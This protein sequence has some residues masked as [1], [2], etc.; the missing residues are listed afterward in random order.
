MCL[1]AS[2]VS[3]HEVF[4]G[5]ERMIFH[6]RKLLKFDNFGA[7]NETVKKWKYIRKVKRPVA[8]WA[9]WKSPDH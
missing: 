6:F 3:L 8:S 4:G 7:K 2:L 1:V 9:F 5:C